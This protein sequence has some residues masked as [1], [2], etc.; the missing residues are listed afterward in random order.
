MIDD[1]VGAPTGAEL[2]AD[3]TAHAWRAAAARPELA[4]TYH[5]VAAGETSW[6]GYARHVIE[7]ARRHGEPIR[8]GA[9][10]IRPIPS[11]AYPQAAP[12]PKNS[13]LDT[14]KLRAR[15]RPRRCRPG[16]PA[17]SAC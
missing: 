4:G 13:R 7:F 17:S 8:V 1:Q 11:S 5:A 9:D 14:S 6:H 16:R 10:A 2:L 3:V 12:R 15:L